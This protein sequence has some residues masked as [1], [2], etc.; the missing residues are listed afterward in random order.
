MQEEHIIYSGSLTK[1]DVE[2][3]RARGEIAGEPIEDVPAEVHRRAV[4]HIRFL[5]QEETA[6]TY[7]AALHH[8]LSGDPELA[9]AYA[10]TEPVV[11]GSPVG[12]TIPSGQPA[13]TGPGPQLISALLDAL[14]K[15]AALKGQPMSGQ[16]Q[17]LLD[18]YPALREA[19]L[20]GEL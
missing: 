13:K 16:L 2:R 17:K 7:S 1:E 14:G 15:L 12:W 19:Y 6:A 10:R 9:T 18:Q 8:V 5:N 20:R 11:T 3:A 4:A